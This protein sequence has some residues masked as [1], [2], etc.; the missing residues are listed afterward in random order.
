[1]MLDRIVEVKREEVAAA[2][3]QR[4][5]AE[6]QARAA[7]APPV[8]NWAAALRQPGRVSLIAE[9]KK[10]SPSK[11]VLRADFDPVEIA[12]TYEANGAAA[13]SVLT[14]AT[15]FQGQPGFLSAIRDAV[16]LPLL[17][18]EFILDPYQLYEARALGADAVLLIVAI[19]SRGA[20]RDLLALSREI[21]LACLVEVHTEAEL[22]TALGTEAGIIGI[23]NR[24]LRTFQ[25]TLETTF[26]L[27]TQIPSERIVVS[28]SGIF[29]REDV[30]RLAAV[31]VEAVLVGEALL[32]AA[33]LGAKVRELAGVERG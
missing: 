13:L 5:V 6:L 32:R 12:R 23:N 18:K 24:D 27:R 16:A 1:M 8:R 21:G 31:G 29:T 22:E 2:K 26:R 10:A 25:T 4:P 9:V 3:R 11:G 33:D 7:E 30:Q 15:F 20:L 19:L 17:R 14:D 28:E